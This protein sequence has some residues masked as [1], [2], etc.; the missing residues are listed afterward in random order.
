MSRN[1]SLLG[2]GLCSM[3]CLGGLKAADAPSA[4]EV[5]LRETLRNTMLQL[6]TSETE[7]AT[8]QAAQT[9][10]DQKNKALSVQVE[11]LTKQ[12]ATDQQT[13]EKTIATLN[14][15]ASN[16]EAELAQLKEAFETLK[17]A[18]KQAADLATAREGQR[19]KLAGDVIALQRK[20]AE[21]QTKNAAMFKL[22]NEILA[23]YEKF[24]LGDALTAREPFIGITRVKFENLMQD[25]QDKLADQKIKP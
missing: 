17:I 15:R 9:E 21:Q 3:L 16:R 23:R 18:E 1:P 5:K 24:G 13:A 25:Y 14:S 8:L 4:A 11:T 20:V 2:L 12:A 6:R 7:R 19:A 10:S 22:G